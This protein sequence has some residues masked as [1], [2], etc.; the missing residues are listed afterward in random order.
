MAKSNPAQ[1]L[2]AAQARIKTLEATVNRLTVERN[3]AQTEVETLCKDVRTIQARRSVTD[4]A[5]RE[6]V[7]T[8]ADLRNALAKSR[9]MS[10]TLGITLLITVGS[11]C[12]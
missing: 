8:A 11:I 9:I 5:H 1:A 10:L 2:L 7:S 3:V 12:L 6:L 4:K